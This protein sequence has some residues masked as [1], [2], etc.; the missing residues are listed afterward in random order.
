MIFYCQ[1]THQSNEGNKSR[2]RK[3]STVQKGGGGVV[4]IFQEFFDKRDYLDN[5]P[6]TRRSTTQ[7]HLLPQFDIFIRLYI[8]SIL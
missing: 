4:G 3:I 2:V 7:H 1:K 5:Q 8:T 6:I